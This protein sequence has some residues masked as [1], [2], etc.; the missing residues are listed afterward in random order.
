[1][2]I[3]ITG[4]VVVNLMIAVIC[5]A[6]H[7]L[8]N[9]DKAGLEGYDAEEGSGEESSVEHNSPE[10]APYTT[11]GRLQEL[12]LQLDE[13]DMVQDQ[14]RKTIEVLIKQLQ[15]SDA[16]GCRTSLPPT[17]HL[18]PSHRSR[19]DPIRNAAGEEV[20]IEGAPTM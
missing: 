11:E 3:I 4:F 20:E 12:Q 2:F 9:S 10:T 5:D 1:M 14:M 13:M 19:T 17:E 6:V 15:G 16:S 8:G 18:H 7:V